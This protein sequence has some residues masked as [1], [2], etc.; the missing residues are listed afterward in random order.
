VIALD[1]RL[2]LNHHYMTLVIV[3]AYLLLPAKRLLIPVL[4]VVMYFWAGVLKL[5]PESDWMSAAAFYGRR[6]FDMPSAW[7]PAACAY[8]VVLEVALVWGLLS[9]IRTI[10]WLTFVQLILFHIGSYWVVGWFYPATMFAL[11]S[12]VPLLWVHPQPPRASYQ[13]GRAIARWTVAMAVVLFSG[14][15]LV[16]WAFPG[17]PAMTGQGRVFALNMFDSPIE[18]EMLAIGTDG[19]Q[20]RLRVPFTNTRIRCD[21][22]VFLGAARDRCRKSGEPFR[23]V[24]RSR[25]VGEPAYRVLV[26]VDDFCARNPRYSLTAPNWWITP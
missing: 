3:G 8:V 5:L 12:I 14:A 18:C 10:A 2:T 7:L 6:P 4:L 25:R 1:F 21:P 19:A 20:Q 9:R 17:D 13:V 24:L 11:L 26:D 16:K 15:Q 22:I 23:A